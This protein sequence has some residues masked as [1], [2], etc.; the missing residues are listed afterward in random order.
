MPKYS[1]IVSMYIIDTIAA[2]AAAIATTTTA[3]AIA[4]TTTATSTTA[5]AAGAAADSVDDNRESRKNFF[6]CI[7]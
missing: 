7:I 4:T 6:H 2:A 3:V 1:N 5:T